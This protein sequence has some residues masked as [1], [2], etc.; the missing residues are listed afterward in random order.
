MIRPQPDALRSFCLFVVFT[1]G[2][3]GWFVP[4]V[5]YGQYEGVN[6]FF[7]FR[8]G[9][10]FYTGSPRNLRT[11][12]MDA[13]EGC[14]CISSR[15]GSLLMYTNGTTVWDANHVPMQNG[16]SL[17]GDTNATHAALIV[18]Q[19]GNQGLYYLFTVP[20]RGGPAGLCYSVVDINQNNG[21]GAVLA[22]QKNVPL[23]P[24]VTE[25]L[26]AVRHANHRDIWLVA[27][28]WNTDRFVAF[29]VTNNGLDPTPVISAVGQVHSGTLRNNRGAMVLA[30][31]G[32][33]LGV[34]VEYQNTVELVDFDPTTGV[35]SNPITYTSLPARPYG[36]AFS[37]D[38]TKLYINGNYYP[39][40]GSR[41]N[42]L[43]QINLA[44]GSPAQIRAS[45]TTVGSYADGLFGPDNRMGQ[46][47]LGPDGRIYIAQNNSPY[48]AIVSQPNL[49]G[50]ACGFV[51]QGYSLGGNISGLGLPTFVQSFFDPPV[52]DFGFQDRKCAGDTVWFTG[53]SS[54]A[55]AQF[56]WNFGDPASGTANA[57]TQQNPGHIFT[58]GGTFTV[59][60]IVE[61]NGLRDTAEKLVRV[62]G[63]PQ[64]PFNG[65][66][67]VACQGQSVVLDA[68]NPGAA[69]AWGN[70]Y[71]TR[72]IT[73]EFPGTYTVRVLNGPCVDIF[74]QTVSF[75]PPPVVSLGS[76]TSLCGAP[77]LTL[78]AGNPGARYIW[79]TGDTTQTLTVTRADNYSVIVS[80]GSGC[81]RADTVFVGLYPGP[82]PNFPPDTTLCPNNADTLILD[83]GPGFLYFWNTGDTTRTI[84]V[85]Q[86]GFFA[87]RVLDAQGCEAEDS[88]LVRDGCVRLYLPTAF[89]PNG[90]GQNDTFR[91]ILTNLADFYMAIYDRWGKLVLETRDPAFAWDGGTYPEGVYLVRITYTNPETKLPNEVVFDL[92]MFR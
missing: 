32:R 17:A 13:P 43:Y 69:Y 60:L 65:Q 31:D 54:E 84:T 20:A 41:V 30:P 39:A 89:T 49:Q 10:D 71:A 15:Q 76:D 56:L 91:F 53:K 36:V 80:T 23:F 27:H 59:T 51:R 87:V 8:C 25:K 86:P 24:A 72:T 33:T 37:P 34:A 66:P 64:N 40:G 63:R 7:G 58:T 67:L 74:S 42:E 50:A 1:F 81:S 70:G 83:A 2:L 61:A 44:A 4:Q 9:I 73:V 28:E 79:S 78:D 85:T 29:L 12:V 46:M 88:T 68:G 35:V 55:N 5:A 38:G 16:R 62:W 90:D 22:G 48:L 92:T 3:L 14:A 75:T 82:Q 57:S 19:P 18:P 21:R 77:S 11:S 52:A 6:W 47:Q 45:F 26:T